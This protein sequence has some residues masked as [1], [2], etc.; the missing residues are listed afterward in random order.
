MA[1]PQF[2]HDC[3]KCQFLGRYTCEFNG[4]CDLYYCGASEFRDTVIARFGDDGPNYTS[5]IPFVGMTP[6]LTEAYDRAIAAGV[7]I[8]NPITAERHADNERR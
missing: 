2:T 4:P 7:E 5:G 1:E 6:A 3:D 8:R